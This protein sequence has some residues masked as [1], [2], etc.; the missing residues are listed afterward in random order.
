MSDSA[1]AQ[2]PLDQ[3]T[4]Q[5]AELNM[6]NP[7]WSKRMGFLPV[8]SGNETAVDK[9]DSL[10]LNS[11]NIQTNDPPVSNSTRS[12]MESSA[13]RYG[14]NSPSDTAVNIDNVRRALR[15]K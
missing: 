2:M 4:A 5:K 8:L 15:N 14:P 3:Q 9:G 12:D 1:F 6:Q 13:R 10:R 11:N 7:T